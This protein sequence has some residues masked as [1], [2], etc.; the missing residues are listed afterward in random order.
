MC[1]HIIGQYF[2][3]EEYR[4][5]LLDIDDFQRPLRYH[6]RLDIAQLHEI[7]MFKLEVSH[8]I[9]VTGQFSNWVRAKIEST[10]ALCVISIN[11][12]L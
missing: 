11:T 2:L 10:N 9:L 12:D 5:I 7:H 3:S 6:C 1:L 8:R 4:S